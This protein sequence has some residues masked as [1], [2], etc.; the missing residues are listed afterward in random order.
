M[1][2]VFG[3]RGRP[4]GGDGFLAGVAQ[5]VRDI[6]QAQQRHRA[7][8]G[9][10]VFLARLVDFEFHV[11]LAARQPDFAHQQ[12]LHFHRGTAGFRSL[13]VREAGGPPVEMKDLLVGESWLASGQ[14]NMEFKVNQTRKEDRDAAAGPVPLLRLFDV[15]HVLSNTRK[16][17]VAAKWTPATPENV[18]HFSAVGYFFGKRISE[19]LKVPVG[20]IHSSWGGSRIEPWWAEEGLEGIDELAAAKTQRLAKSP[21][22]PGYDRRYRQYVSS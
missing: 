18:A 20:I 14:S 13:R 8:R 10:P 5:D 7:S 16:E 1:R 15:P 21:G 11:R 3:S 2:H 6:E 9:V 4:F 12:I 22:F 17:T 19:E